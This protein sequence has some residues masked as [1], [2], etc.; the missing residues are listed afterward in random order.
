MADKVT[1]AYEEACTA[2]ARLLTHLNCGGRPPAVLVQRADRALGKVSEAKFEAQF[3]RSE[4]PKLEPSTDFIP[5]SLRIELTGQEAQIVR[6]ALYRFAGEAR[7]AAAYGN[8]G[9]WPAHPARFLDDASSAEAV[10]RKIADGRRE[11]L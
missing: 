10:L 9:F 2:L 3:A 7:A 6:A 4:N 8:L 5:P 11:H 1:A